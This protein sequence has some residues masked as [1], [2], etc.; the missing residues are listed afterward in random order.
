[1][2][3]CKPAL[4]LIFV[5]AMAA[6]KEKSKKEISVENLPYIKLPAS[7]VWYDDWSKEP[8]VM[9]H[10]MTEPDNLHPANG[11]SQTRAELFLYLHAGLLRVDLRTGSLEPGI[12][13]RLPELSADQ[14]ELIFELRDD[15]RWDNGSKLSAEDVIFTIKAAKCP[16][17]DN[18][19]FKPYFDLVD[20]AEKVQG[21][22][23]RVKIKMKKVYVQNLALWADYPIIQRAL[24]DPD[25]VL[26]NFSFAQFNDTSFHAGDFKNLVAWANDFNAPANGFDPSKI[27]G[28]GPYKVNVWQQGQFI[29]LRKKANHWTDNSLHYAE[30]SEPEKIIFKMNADAVTLELGFMKQEFDASTSMSARTLLKLKEDS[31]FNRNYHSRFVDIY[32]YTFI[33]LNMRPDEK[34]RSVALKDLSVR[35][36]LAL[37]TPVDD[38][39]KVVNKGVN[40]RVSGPVTFMK[41]S[42]NSS[43]PLLPY[44]LAAANA[45]LDQA[46]W[47]MDIKKG[48]RYKEENGK[49]H[50]LELELLYMSAVPE[51]REMALMIS[52][53]MQRAGI[54]LYL[55]A[56]DLNVWLEKGTG[57]DFD[58]IMG[59]WNSSALPEDYSQLWSVKSWKN[60]GLNFTGF[61]NDESDRLI[62]SISVTMNDSV[63]NAM[64]FRLQQLIYEEQPYV[65]LY[66]LVRRTAVHRRFNHAELYAERPGILYNLLKVNSLA[67]VKAMANP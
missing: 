53:S 60:L 5:V 55:S 62:D 25:A 38:I 57:H 4:F 59:S 32:G 31:S 51:W 9:V 58:M 46:G 35:K 7:E 39:I 34:N 45:L 41:P 6:C 16:L 23:D 65:F 61:G 52:E 64:E 28:L 24:Y 47:K 17:T 1:M 29:E 54:K 49:I 12:A 10:E 2:K 21:Q 44:D 33:G 18:S 11:N 15:V 22:P 40:K 66:G 27:S 63:R 36:S 56:V 42:C 67:G 19:G 20:K 48:L 14:L 43:L 50:W 3:K 8:V 37:I 13:K 26:D 30:K